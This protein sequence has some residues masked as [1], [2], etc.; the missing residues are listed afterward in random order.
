MLIETISDL[1][2]ISET[3][4]SDSSF[5]DLGCGDGVAVVEIA[6]KFKIRAIGVDLD[7]NLCRKAELLAVEAGCDSLV[8]IRR[9][10]FSKYQTIDD[11]NPAPTIL[12]MYLL[13][14]ALESLRPAL[15]RILA[16]RPTLIIITEVWG[17]AQWETNRFH[18][19]ESRFH[20]Y[21]LS[22][23]TKSKS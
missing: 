10:N 6:T 15:E 19:A 17:V 4:T 9:Q 11:F 5:W 7:A 20:F 14:E 21:S 2:I 13:P 3:S 23:P 18:V 1:H 12:F 8:E 22:P 16:S